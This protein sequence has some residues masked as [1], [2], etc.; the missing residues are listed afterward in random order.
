MRAARASTATTL[1]AVVVAATVVAVAAG[2]ST[3]AKLRVTFDGTSSGPQGKFKLFPA[4]ALRGDSGTVI[5]GQL[6]TPG[7]MILKG[8]DVQTFT[9]TDTYKGA[10]GDLTVSVSA[11]Q[12]AAPPY[13]IY[14]GTWKLISGTGAYEGYKGGGPFAAVEAPTGKVSFREQGYLTKG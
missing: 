8:Q 14:T 6:P 9:N 5:S 4:G 1:I 3:T 11:Q 10:H 13:N 2:G 7:R 12:V